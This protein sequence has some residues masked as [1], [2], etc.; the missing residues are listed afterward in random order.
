MNKEK[1]KQNIVES[2]SKKLGTDCRISI[3]TFL[4]TNE[5][6]DGLLILKDGENLSPTIYLDS[7]YED[8]DNGKPLDDVVDDILNTYFQAKLHPV[9]LDTASITDFNKV[10]N[11]LYVELVNKHLNAEMLKDAPH[12]WFLDDFAVVVRYLVEATEHKNSN[13]L[14]HKEFLDIWGVDQDFLLSHAL[15]N[16]KELMGLELI[17]IEAA[18]AKPP[19]ASEYAPSSKILMWVM[20][21]KLHFSGAATVL[22]DDALRMFVKSQDCN[23]YVIFSSIHEV[24]LIP[25]SDNVELAFM[26]EINSLVNAKE[27]PKAEILGTK[28]Y[29]YTKEHGF[30]NR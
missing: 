10:K 1:H 3:Q 5:K 11:R 15:Q 7:F 23:F 4:K 17:P 9:C 12:T 14:V 26:T 8:L 29:Y 22:F 19:I 16:T 6:L 20:T 30:N 28:A 25:T 18:A 27:M 21:N 13:F 24:L 2:L